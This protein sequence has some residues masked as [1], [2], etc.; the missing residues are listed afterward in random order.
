[1]LYDPLLN[2]LNL[3]TLEIRRKKLYLFVLYKLLN[4]LF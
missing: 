2:R 4:D 1:M 3:N